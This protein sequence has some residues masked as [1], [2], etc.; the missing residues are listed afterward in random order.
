MTFNI[1]EL[2]KLPMNI[3]SALS[4]ASGSILFLP[5][6]IIKKMYMIDFR[7]KY[8]FI[9]GVVFTVS[10]CILIISI[11]INIY[12]FLSKEYWNFKFKKNSKK[13]L[14]SLDDY[15]KTIVYML[16]LE[17]NNTSELPL[18]DGGVVFLE[19][20]RFIQKATSQYVVDNMRNPM[21]PYFLQPWVINELQKDEE[22]LLSF[23]RAAEKH[24]K[25]IEDN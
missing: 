7:T 23:K 11:L 21:F 25:K 16:Y 9:I 15:K 8:G 2:F 18:N 3:I 4:L 19:N 10:T 1:T 13:L 12:K 22:V 5:D 6:E 14:N 24:I 17:D 20:F